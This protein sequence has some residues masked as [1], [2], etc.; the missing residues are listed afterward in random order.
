M[1]LTP[2]DIENVEFPRAVSGYHRGQVDA[3]LEDVARDFEALTRENVDLRQ[4]VEELGKRLADYLRLEESIRNALVLAQTTADEARGAAKRESE[5][6]LQQARQDAARIVEDA[7]AQS[8]EAQ[9]AAARI[10]QQRERFAL[11]FG[12]LLR[13]HLAALENEPKG[14]GE[15]P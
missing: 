10:R 15:T 1:R 4:Q 9:D 2:L 5:L 7:R 8:R 3:F 11:E 6:V 12:A 13:S 14:T